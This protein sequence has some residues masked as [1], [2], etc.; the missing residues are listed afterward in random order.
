MCK[1]LTISILT[2]Q[3]V[4]KYLEKYDE[5]VVFWNGY[6]MPFNLA[7]AIAMERFGVWVTPEMIFTIERTHTRLVG[8]GAYHT[9][10]ASERLPT[11]IYYHLTSIMELHLSTTLLN[12]NAME[13]LN[14]FDCSQ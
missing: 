8:L 3:P 12:R 5:Y 6:E 7:M 11:L 9:A 14:W 4:V 10:A 1:E 13:V 2:P